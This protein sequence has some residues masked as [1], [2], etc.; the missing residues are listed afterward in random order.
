MSWHNYT[1]GTL[2][3]F[4]VLTKPFS[5]SIIFFPSNSIKFLSL[6]ISLLFIRWEIENAVKSSYIQC[7]RLVTTNVDEIELI[8]LKNNL[9]FLRAVGFAHIFRHKQLMD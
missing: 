5:V 1:V 9:M 6:S 8:K 3:N 2:L 4:S 7:Y